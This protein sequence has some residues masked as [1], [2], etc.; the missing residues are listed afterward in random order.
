[1]FFSMMVSTS[2]IIYFYSKIKTVVGCSFFNTNPYHFH[3]KTQFFIFVHIMKSSF[4]HVFVTNTP[5]VTFQDIE[6]NQ[7]DMCQNAILLLLNIT[8]FGD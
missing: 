4:C 3:N 2:I 7:E 5:F 6:N 1:M 8:I